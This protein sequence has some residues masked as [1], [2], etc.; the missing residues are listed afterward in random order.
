MRGMDQNLLLSFSD[1]EHEHWWFVTRRRIVM[2]AIGDDVSPGA[3]ILEVG[4]GTGSLL[5]GLR[6]RFPAAHL[7]GVE[8]CEAA[9]GV[10]RDRGCT[11]AEGTLEEVASHHDQ[12]VDLLVAL[13]VLEH[14]QDDA[15]ALAGARGAM[16]PGARMVLTVPALPSLWSPHDEANQHYR[17]YT[18]RTLRRAI[19]ESGLELERLTYFNTLLLPLAYVTRLLARISRSSSLSGVEMPHPLVNAT[20]TA[21]FSLEVGLLRHLDLPLGMSLLAVVRKPGE[22]GV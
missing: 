11:V 19:D 4:C 20:L 7:S 2:Q 22:A 12:S 9:V 14:C 1:V 10:A 8:P 3:N 21:L 5:L 16:R 18:A 6:E 13:D 15:L 17:R